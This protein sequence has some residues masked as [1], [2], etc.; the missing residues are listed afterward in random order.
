MSTMP[1][2]RRSKPIK[3]ARPRSAVPSAAPTTV[4]RSARCR[5]SPAR[6]VPVKR[7]SRLMPRLPH[8]SPTSSGESVRRRSGTGVTPHVRSLGSRRPPFAGMTQIRFGGSGLPAPSQ[9]LDS[10]SPVLGRD[11]N[12]SLDPPDSTLERLLVEEVG[13]SV[14]DLVRRPVERVG[15]GGAV[16]RVAHRD[17]VADNE[18]APVRRGE[19]SAERL[20]VAARGVVEAFAAR[21]GLAARVPV[22]PGTVVLE[23]RA[24]EL[25]EVD[26]VEERLDEQRDVLAL[27]A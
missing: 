6:N 23:H 18:H 3:P 24:F 26:V 4:A 19:E 1:G 2:T 5:P 21:E 17:L 22:L 11:V 10:D 16:E 25:S 7:T 27:G 15:T 13:D 8:R 12:G 9:P 20:R 14:R